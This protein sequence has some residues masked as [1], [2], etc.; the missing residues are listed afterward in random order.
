MKLAMQIKLEGFN[1]LW[2]VW[3]LIHLKKERLPCQSNLGFYGYV[4]REL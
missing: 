1:L 2:R 3:L 4:N